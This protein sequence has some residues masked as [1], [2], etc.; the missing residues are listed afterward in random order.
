MAGYITRC[1]YKSLPVLYRYHKDWCLLLQRNS[2]SPGEREKYRTRS[3]AEP[4]HKKLK[5]EEK[6]MG[7]VRT[8]RIIITQTCVRLT[9]SLHSSNCDDVA[10]I[11]CRRRQRRTH[12]TSQRGAF[13]QRERS[14]QTSTQERTSPS[15]SAVRRY[16]VFTHTTL[17]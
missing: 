7:H 12:I 2:I 5:K 13:T 16:T 11:S 9:S 1:I 8:A 3:P 15:Q 17:H 10:G 14:G 4:D 6:D